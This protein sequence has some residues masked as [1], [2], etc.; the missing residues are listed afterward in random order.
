MI[1]FLCSFSKLSSSGAPKGA[2]TKVSVKSECL[3]KT[4]MTFDFGANENVELY[5]ARLKHLARMHAVV[6]FFLLVEDQTGFL[7]E[8]YQYIGRCACNKYM[9]PTSPIQDFSA[10]QANRLCDLT[11]TVNCIDESVIKE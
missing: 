10:L 11:L 7:P 2:N 9:T 6:E 3:R 4:R 8:T 5:S 1:L